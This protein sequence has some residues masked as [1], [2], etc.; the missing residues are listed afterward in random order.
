[1]LFAPQS[2]RQ[3]RQQIADKTLETKEKAERL[4]RNTTD[5][6]KQALTRVADKTKAAVRE[7]QRAAR[8]S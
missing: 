7:G 3:T 6:T 1:M 5:Q 8:E 4:A 2:G